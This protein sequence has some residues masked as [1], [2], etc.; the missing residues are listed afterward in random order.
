MM[1]L[2]KMTWGSFTSR[3][4]ANT[5][6]INLVNMSLSLALLLHKFQIVTI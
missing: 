2:K 5:T 3:L 1:K 6:T 4:N